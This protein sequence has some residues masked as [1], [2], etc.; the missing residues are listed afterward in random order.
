[1]YENLSI[2]DKKITEVINANQNTSPFTLGN[3]EKSN[4][5][6]GLQALR[7]NISTDVNQDV[8]DLNKIYDEVKEM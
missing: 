5:L 4:S 6:L 2:D 3:E 8:D 7:P 1:M